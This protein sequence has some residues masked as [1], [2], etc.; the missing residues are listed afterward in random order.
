MQMVHPEQFYERILTT[1]Q[2]KANYQIKVIDWGDNESQ[3]V[4]PYSFTDIFTDFDEYLLAEG[5]HEKM[6][7]RLG[8]HLMSLNGIAGVHFAVWAPNAARVS[9]VGD[10]NAWDGRRHPMRFR[11]NSGLW[12]IFIPGLTQGTIY[13]F[14]IK[15]REQNYIVTKADPVAY[16]NEVRPNTASIVWDINQYKWQDQD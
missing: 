10:F 6:Y 8:A 15:A 9:V 5:T 4:D 2:Y 1:K 11:H 16:Y 3:F 12:N 13:K 14:E 7:E